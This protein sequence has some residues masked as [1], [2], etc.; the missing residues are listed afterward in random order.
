MKARAKIYPM[1]QLKPQDDYMKTALRLPR[2]LH[3]KIQEEAAASGRSM[4][5]EIVARLEASFAEAPSLEKRLANLEH[6][7]A[8]E[9]VK[10]SKQWTQTYGFAQ[11]LERL[12]EPFENANIPDDNPFKQELAEIRKMVDSFKPEIKTGLKEAMSAFSN[13]KDIIENVPYHHDADSSKPD[14]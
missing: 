4:N 12:L 7:M 5:A 10:T 13:M 1:A 6:R 3:A 2:D 8:F 11:A 14:Q 9:K